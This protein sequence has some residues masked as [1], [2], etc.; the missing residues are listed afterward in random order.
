MT[1]VDAFT[2]KQGIASDEIGDRRHYRREPT[3]LEFPNLGIALPESDARSWVDWH[4]DFVVKGNSD[5][6][7][8]KTGS[9]VF[10]SPDLNTELVRIRFANLGIFRLAPAGSAPGADAVRRI[11]AKL[12]CERM[13]FL[14]SDKAVPAAP[15]RAAPARSARG[16]KARRAR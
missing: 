1:N 9:L 10:L 12:Y 5:E 13:E 8:E 7:R 15:R 4:E 14:V 2:V 11:T 3:A 6:A 16:T